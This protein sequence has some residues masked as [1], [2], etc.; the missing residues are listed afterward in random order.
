MTEAE[1]DALRLE[2]Y[3]LQAE[4]ARKAPVTDPRAVQMW[5]DAASTLARGIAHTA[6][7]RPPKAS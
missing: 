4:R 2:A 6:I 1:W 3:R 7:T 5:E